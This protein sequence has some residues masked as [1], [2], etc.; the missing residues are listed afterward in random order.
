MR[1]RQWLVIE[2]R[3]RVVIIAFDLVHVRE[4]SFRPGFLIPRCARELFRRGIGDCELRCHCQRA[5]SERMTSR[6]IGSIRL[7]QV[8]YSVDCSRSVEAT[9]CTAI[10]MLGIRHR[11]GTAH[12]AVTDFVNRD[13]T[14]RCLEHRTN[15]T[16]DMRR[17]HRGTGASDKQ[18]FL[19]NRIAGN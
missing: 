15:G 13:G 18:P 19:L 12:Q 3:G 16:R 1:R 7:L 4:Y 5:A 11:F 14:A 17:C 9:P 2:W 6:R 10:R 8:A